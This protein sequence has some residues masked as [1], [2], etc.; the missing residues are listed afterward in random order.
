MIYKDRLQSCKVP[1]LAIAGDQDLICPPMSVTGETPCVLCF[2][3]YYDGSPSIECRGEYKCR[4]FINVKKVGLKWVLFWVA[5]S[6]RILNMQW[7]RGDWQIQIEAVVITAINFG[8]LYEYHVHYRSE[9]SHSS[10]M[11]G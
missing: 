3:G 6:P 4:G 10:Q 5:T 8:A 7:V 1:V 9:D 11:I 2:M